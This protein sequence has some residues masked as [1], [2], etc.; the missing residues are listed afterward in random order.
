MGS[1]SKCLAF[2]LVVEKGSTRESVLVPCIAKTPSSAA[3]APRGK[4]TA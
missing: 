1:V 2:K 4:A 3:V